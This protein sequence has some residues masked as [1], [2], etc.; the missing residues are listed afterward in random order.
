MTEYKFNN[1]YNVI[2]Y[3]LSLLLDCFESEDQHFA[4]QYTWWLASIIQ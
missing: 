2:L 3:T 4:A 1:E